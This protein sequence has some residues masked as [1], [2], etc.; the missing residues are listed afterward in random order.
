MRIRI[1]DR[2]W[3][4]ERPSPGKK[5]CTS[6]ALFKN[7]VDF[8][9]ARKSLMGVCLHSFLYIFFGWAGSVHA[10]INGSYY[11]EGGAWR[12]PLIPCVPMCDHAPAMIRSVEWN[13]LLI[14]IWAK[15]GELQG[16]MGTK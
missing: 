11:F 13:V 8:C 3:A 10:F 9:T 12:G 5:S 7:L 4:K 1:P 15:K 2:P 6:K 14:K 16:G